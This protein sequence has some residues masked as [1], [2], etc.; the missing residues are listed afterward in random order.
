MNDDL[1]GV[2]VEHTQ[3]L[4]GNRRQI[5]QLVSSEDLLEGDVG[6]LLH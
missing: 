6:V 2:F 5:G 3:V 4:D 1:L